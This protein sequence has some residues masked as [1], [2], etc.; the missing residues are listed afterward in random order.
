MAERRKKD[1]EWAIDVKKRAK[2]HC[3]VEK[4]NKRKWLNAHHIYSRNHMALRHNIE[5]GVALCVKHHFWAH[6]CGMEFAEWI[7]NKRGQTW[8]EGL[9]AIKAQSSSVEN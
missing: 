6:Q 9:K 1:K 5:N 2:G 4:C 7:V 3:E 8:L